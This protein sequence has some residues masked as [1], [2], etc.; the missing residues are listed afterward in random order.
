MKPKPIRLYFRVAMLLLLFSARFCL[1]KV[2]YLKMR[3]IQFS[4]WVFW[5]T[6]FQCA[7]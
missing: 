7:G 5:D 4:D 2:I 1:K 3:H 6:S